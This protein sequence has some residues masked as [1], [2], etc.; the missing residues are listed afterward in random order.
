MLVEPAT[1][2]QVRL[3]RTGRVV[4]LSAGESQA[5]ADLEL[6][7]RDLGFPLELNFHEESQHWSIVQRHGPGEDDVT[8]IATVT[9]AQALPAAVEQ[10]RRNVFLLRHGRLDLAAELDARDDARERE[11]DR[12]L[13]E[14]L[15][16][17]LERAAVEH[18]VHA[19]DRMFV[20]RAI[21]RDGST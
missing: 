15:D 16:E 2:E 20:P 19:D 11:I 9:Q 3:G 4:I 8:L 7:G 14:R 18:R 17:R 5:A 10:V 1:I 21:S 6:L 13:E 12:R